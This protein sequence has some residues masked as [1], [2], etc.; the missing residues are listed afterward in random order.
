MS[1]EDSESYLLNNPYALLK[2]YAK[3]SKIYA[4]ALSLSENYYRQMYKYIMYP[5]VIIS[6]VSS[7]LSGMNMNNYIVMSLNL[8]SLILL[9][10]NST[11]SPKDKE[12][13]AHN[14]AVEFSEINRS[15]KQ[16]VYSN[17]RS[18]SEIKQYSELIASQMNIWIGLSPPIK[19]RFIKEAKLSCE[20][21]K[22]KDVIFDSTIKKKGEIN[23]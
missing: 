12:K 7:V 6:A 17:N 15:I 21:R 4:E 22:H 9:G 11:I 20:T 19:D 3:K 23:V 2:D 8:S 10:F 1:N 14:I 18:R 5:M 13:E 16:F